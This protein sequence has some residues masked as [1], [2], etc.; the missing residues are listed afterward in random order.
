VTCSG[1][2]RFSALGNSSAGGETTVSIGSTSA[3]SVSF[4]S[5]LRISSPQNLASLSNGL[6]SSGSR[7]TSPIVD[8]TAGRVATIS[9]NPSKMSIVICYICITIIY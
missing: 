8:T 6:C 5:G 7:N 2:G 1:I 3:S 9:R 4:G